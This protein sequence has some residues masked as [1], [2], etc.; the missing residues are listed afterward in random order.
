M[1][2]QRRINYECYIQLHRTDLSDYFK[3]V[4]GSTDTVQLLAPALRTPPPFAPHTALT[5]TLV[6]IECEHPPPTQRRIK[7]SNVPMWPAPKPLPP[8]VRS[9]NM[10][11]AI[12]ILM[13]CPRYRS[14]ILSKHF[15]PNSDSDNI[16][17][18]L[19][20]LY[21]GTTPS[22]VGVNATIEAL[23]K[24]RTPV[25]CLPKISKR[26]AKAIATIV[27]TLRTYCDWPNKV[28]SPP[29]PS[30]TTPLLAPN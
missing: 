20:D 17:S 6:T 7:A 26:N 15:P 29:P 14:A 23:R 19:M 21:L 27:N 4:L 10:D 16:K 11:H 25:A 9:N 3:R 24:M 18:L 8:S 30:P 28:P 22:Q 2:P 13:S 5:S 12:Q 1:D